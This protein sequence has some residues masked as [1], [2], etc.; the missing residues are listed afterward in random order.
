MRDA[1][2]RLDRQ[3]RFPTGPIVA[4]N[5][6]RVCHVWNLNWQG[7]QAGAGLS[8]S[9][10]FVSLDEI[11]VGR[12]CPKKTRPWRAWGIY[13]GDKRAR[14]NRSSGAD[15]RTSKG[16]GTCLN[17]RIYVADLHASCM[18]IQYGVGCPF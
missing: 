7:L 9:I 11:F 17:G 10:E 13:P 4:W 3:L 5:I 6:Q 12:N 1:L 15:Q 14:R 18:L 16:I 2:V 8:K